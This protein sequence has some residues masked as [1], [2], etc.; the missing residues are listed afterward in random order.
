MSLGVTTSHD[1]SNWLNKKLP[2]HALPSKSDGDYFTE[3]V[4][5]GD[6]SEAILAAGE[7][8]EADLIVLGHKGKG[9]IEKFL[10]G[11]VTPRIAHHTCRSLLA[12]R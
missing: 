7:E 12:V 3:L 8:L 10:M 9:A 11:S 2:K 4:E 1:L 5:A 6:V